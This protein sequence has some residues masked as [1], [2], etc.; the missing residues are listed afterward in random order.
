GIEKEYQKE[1]M[2]IPGGQ[3]VEVD[4]MGRPIKVL[5]MLSPTPGATIVTTIDLSL[6]ELAERSLEKG[7]LPGA[8]VV[9]NPNNGEILAMASYPEFDPNKF[10]RGITIEEWNE[11]LSPR[12][13]LVNRAISSAYPPGS[14]FKIVTALAALRENVASKDSVFYCPGYI[15]IGNRKFKD[16]TAHGRIDFLDAIAE[17]CDVTFYTLGLK[18]GAETLAKYARML[19]LGRPTEV[20]LPGEIAGL[21]PDPSWKKDHWYVGDTANMAIGQGYVQVTPIQMAVMVSA[22]ANGG[23][24]YRPRIVSE[25]IKQDGS[26]VVQPVTVANDLS[27]FKKEISI[28]KE[29]MEMVVEKGTGTPARLSGIKV[30]GKTGTA[31]NLPTRDNPKGKAHAWFIAYAPADDPKI[32]VSVIVEQGE[33]GSSTAA[34]IAAELIDYY[35][36]G[37]KIQRGGEWRGD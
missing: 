33:H 37:N 2:G 12:R 14:T 27:R 17:S 13:P 34:P 36:T 20:D 11:L 32:A 15:M 31:E 6:Q 30:A 22:I 16:W 8:I 26:K 3:Q 10:A 35:L 25:I 18:L 7:G 9:M 1:L 29:G 4:A 23:K 5:G 19:G 24:V 21:I 28:I